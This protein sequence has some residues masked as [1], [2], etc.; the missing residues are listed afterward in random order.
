PKVSAE[1]VQVSSK[2][3]SPRKPKPTCSVNRPCCA[4]AHPTWSRQ[5]SKCSPKPATSQ[6][7]PTS[8]Y[9][10]N[11]SSSLT[12]WSKVASPNSAG[13]SPIPLKSVTTFPDPASSMLA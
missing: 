13:P 12:S 11:S 10:T 3:P 9:C 6:K 7:S 5:D 8:R 1:P 2:P 4:V